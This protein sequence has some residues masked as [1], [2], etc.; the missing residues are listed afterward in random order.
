M[1]SARGKQRTDSEAAEELK[2][3]V[4]QPCGMSHHAEAK[5]DTGLWRSQSARGPLKK[6]Q[7]TFPDYRQAALLEKIVHP[8][9]D[10]LIL[11]LCYD[12]FHPVH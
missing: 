3:L 4:C 8:L 11:P 12:G 7:K 5:I 10:M 9:T 2:S 1:H 6:Q